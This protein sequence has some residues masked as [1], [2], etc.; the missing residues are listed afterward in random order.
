M[1]KVRTSLTFLISEA[2]T[3]LEQRRGHPGLPQITPHCSPWYILH[4]STTSFFT[5]GSF[6]KSQTYRTSWP[7]VMSLEGPDVSEDEGPSRDSLS[8]RMSLTMTMKRSSQCPRTRKSQM[9][10]RAEKRDWWRRRR[11]KRRRRRRRRRMA[12]VS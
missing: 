6:A 10:Q 4:F 5:V 8:T 7:S 11:R 1:A 9:R 12:Q 3:N 2:T